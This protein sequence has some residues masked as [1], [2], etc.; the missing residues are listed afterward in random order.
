MISIILS[1]LNLTTLPTDI[2][3]M[4]DDI[5][6]NLYP[7]HPDDVA[8]SLQLLRTLKAL[9]LAAPSGLLVPLLK[10]VQAGLCIWIE[11]KEEAIS[12]PEYNDVV[13]VGISLERNMTLQLDLQ[14]MSLYAD[15]LDELCKQP[16]SV[17]FLEDLSPFLASSFTRIPAPALGPLAFQAFW[18]ASYHRKE[19]FLHDIPA[20]V[21][22][23]MKAFDDAFGSDLAIGL[24]HD[25]ESQSTVCS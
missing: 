21:K 18:R 25:S 2:F 14:M 5:L 1:H 10:T 8:A 23:C 17:Q 19:E 15:S 6:V 9:F 11:D 22:V 4:V 16:L 7:P 3:T 24:S 20:R 12:E 13:C